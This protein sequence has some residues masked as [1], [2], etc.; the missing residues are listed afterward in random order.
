M[1]RMLSKNVLLAVLCCAA[2]MLS[3]FFSVAAFERAGQPEQKLFDRMVEEDGHIFGINF[4]WMQIGHTLT[5]NDLM[6]K[7]DVGYGYPSTVALDV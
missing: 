7:Y 2:L 6:E 1:G 4:P 3:C 5:N